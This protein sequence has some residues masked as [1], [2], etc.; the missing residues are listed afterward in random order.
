MTKTNVWINQDIKVQEIEKTLL[1]PDERLTGVEN[2]QLNTE[3]DFKKIPHNGGCYWITT[4]EPIKHAFHKNPLPNEIDSFE[5]IYNG[6]AIQDVQ[7]RI[8][9]HLLI[10]KEDPGWSGIRIDLLLT[11]HDAHH[12]QKALSLD[13]KARVPNIDSIPIK[14]LADLYKLHL[15]YEEI[16]YIKGNEEEKVFYFKNGINVFHD[17]HKNYKYKVFF[18]TGLKSITYLDFIEKMWRSKHGLPRLCTYITGR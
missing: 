17:K 16:S 3:D 1:I 7:G 15:S 11:S 8:K 13:K 18:I 10:K 6:I 4:N 9:R 5:I 12:R 14:S 2:V